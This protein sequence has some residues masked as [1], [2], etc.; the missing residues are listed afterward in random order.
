M[1][2]QKTE[3]TQAESLAQMM[4]A[5]MEERKKALY[6]HKMPA[7]ND[8]Q[9]MLEAMTKAEL[10]DIRYNLNVSGASSLKKAELAEKLVPEIINFARMWLPS[11]LLEEYECFQHLILEKGKSAK[12][13]DD[14]VRLDYL[15]GLGFLSCGKEDDQLVWYMP[16]EIRA[17]FKKLDSP[18]FEALATMNTE[19]TRLTA[20]CLFYY[21]YMNYEELYTLVA[22]QLEADQREDLSFKDF[23]G[24]M[25]N[26]S[27]WSN[28][29]VALP[30]GVKYY[31]LIDESA[32]ED[33]Q[34]KHS[35]L[36]FAKFTYSQLWEAGA[37][38]HIDA[39]TEYKDLA[40]FFMRE[41]GCDVLKAAD[42]VGEI[43]ILLQN[44]GNLQEAAEYLEQLGMMDDERKMKAVVPLLIAY[45]NETHLWPLKGHTPSELFAKSGM[46]KVIPF[47]EV[48]RQK[49]GRNDPCP[50][51]SGKKYKNCCLAKDEN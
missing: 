23:V 1:E 11:I 39:T 40:Q 28:T 43:L 14:D 17:E 48:H 15:R 22:G 42:I 29:L 27:C 49:V 19:I 6:R 8:L 7:R 24:V 16:E 4:E 45:N 44:G 34:R 3:M 51:G 32:L 21:G 25:L 31:T 36:D 10:D 12:L 35:N 13:R 33:E 18:N 20:G 30:Q 47:A 2:A 5:D 46:G 41:H 9:S 26:A 50:C 37:D 38:N